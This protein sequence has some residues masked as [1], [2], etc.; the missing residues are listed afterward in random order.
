[1]TALHALQGSFQ[2]AVLQGSPDFRSLVEEGPRGHLD[3]RL[4]IYAEGYRSRLIEAFAPDFE[5]LQSVMG[6]ALFTT[7]CRQFV[8][9]TPSPH[10]SIRWYAGA[11]P[12]FL[13]STA[14]WSAHPL[15]AEMARFEW[16]LTLAF[17]APDDP[18]LG[19]D[20]LA[21]L[22]SEAWGTLGFRMHPSVHFLDLRHNTAAL[23]KAVDADTDMP[24]PAPAEHPVTW[25]VWRRDLEV[26]YCSLTEPEAWALQAARGGRTFPELCEGLCAWFAPDDVPGQASAWLREWIGDQMLAR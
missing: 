4:A 16:T 14:P 6:D 13:T 3:A 10:R 22:P 25:L 9:A 2:A 7:L 15:L 21:A 8:D 11:L 19:F 17:D 12:D 18:L 23:R 26:H 24:A 5:A 1:M 20:D